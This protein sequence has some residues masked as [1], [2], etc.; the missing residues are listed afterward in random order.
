VFL[1]TIYTQ[2]HY[3]VDALAGLVWALGLQLVVLPALS[4][5]YQR[6]PV[7]VLPVSAVP[8]P[9]TGGGL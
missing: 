1:A 5:G 4:A 3:P 9:I 6:P 2:N 8:E 7:P